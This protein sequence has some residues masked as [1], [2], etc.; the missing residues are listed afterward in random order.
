MAAA[1]FIELFWITLTSRFPSCMTTQ[2]NSS[3]GETR[4][5]PTGRRRK[6]WSGPGAL[7]LVVGALWWQWAQT[8]KQ[9]Q[10]GKAAPGVNSLPAATVSGFWRG[11]VTYSWRPPYTARVFFQT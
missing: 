4:R 6:I 9:S 1:F 11:E 2:R 7:L 10:V 8:Q 3:S 5:Q